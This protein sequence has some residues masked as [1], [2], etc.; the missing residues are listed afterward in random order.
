MKTYNDVKLED[1]MSY[2]VFF[3]FVVK[4]VIREDMFK[5]TFTIV[6]KSVR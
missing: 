4:K 6:K 3:F 2:S 5:K 1:E